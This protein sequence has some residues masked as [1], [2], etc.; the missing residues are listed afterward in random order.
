MQ[1]LFLIYSVGMIFLLF[2]RQKVWIVSTYW[3]TIRWNINVVPFFTIH[4]QW[5]F[6]VKS[7]YDIFSFA[8]I[9]LIGNVI[10][11]V[12]LGFFLPLFYQKLRHYL[13]FI[14][15][16]TG[17]IFVVEIVQLFSLLGSLD[18]D[19]LILNLV[20]ASLGYVIFRVWRLLRF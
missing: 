9:N 19:D 17:I 16:V 13:R 10:M 7:N 1:V 14:F 5:D 6:F 11:F 12:P 18:V 3:E 8:G 2:G 4:S 15:N 20:G